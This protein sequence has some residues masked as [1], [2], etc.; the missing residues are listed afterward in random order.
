MP[1]L[2]ADAKAG[3]LYRQ[4]GAPPKPPKGLSRRATAIWR[5]VTAARAG[6]FFDEG[7][8]PLLRQYCVMSA[9]AETLEKQLVPGQTKVLVE[10]LRVVRL[11]STLAMRL[12][13]TPQAHHRRD[14]AIVT[15]RAAPSSPLIGGAAVI[16]L[17]EPR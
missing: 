11:V 16:R 10:H 8:L 2:S 14:A 6:D 15:E 12:R 9:L 17:R 13:L 3:A 4:G 7:S 5:E 1:R